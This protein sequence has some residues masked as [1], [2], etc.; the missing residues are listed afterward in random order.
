V[1]VPSLPKVPELKIPERTVLAELEVTLI[2]RLFGGGAKAR[3]LDEVCWL[4]PAALKSALRFWWRAGHAHRF[5]TLEALREREEQLFGSSARYGKEKEILGGPGVLEVEVEAAR[6][7]DSRTEEFRPRSGA[8]LN[9]AYFSAEKPACTLAKPDTKTCAR[10]T[11]RAELA[12]DEDRNEILGALRLLL[13]LG[14]IG[15][16]TRRGAGAIAPKTAGD[17]TRHGIP[18]SLGELKGFL[19]QWRR[20]EDKKGPPPGVFALG[21]LRAAFIG[22]DFR[23]AEEAQDCALQVL[24]EFRQDRPHPRAWKG[25]AGWGQT[26]WPEADA[27]R[28]KDG[29]RGASKS[30]WPHKPTDISRKDQYP[31]A[32]LGL[33]IVMHYKDHP[34][35]PDDY[36]ISAALP[37]GRDW[38]RI[39]RFSSPLLIRPVAIWE[40]NGWRFVPVVAIGPYTLPSAARPLVERVKNGGPQG[41]PDRSNLVA[42]FA[43]DRAAGSILSKLEAAFDAVFTRIR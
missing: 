9:I 38:K 22:P 39:S 27:I 33:P 31:R 10:L 2:T 34:A 1:R 36:V 21:S 25:P 3:Q 41:K 4:R 6:I 11:L 28:Y 14:G 18:A 17:A 16:R 30:A 8:A 40:G 37:D 29:L 7:P 26:K 20:P 15:S 12:S 35:D 42:T 43:I 24:R 13:V 5:A 32:S 23:L 19:S